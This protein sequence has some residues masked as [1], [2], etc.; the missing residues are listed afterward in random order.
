MIKE[1]NMK[2]PLVSIITVCLNSEKYIEQAI[3]S[4]ICQTYDN[5]EYIVIDGCSTDGTL[6]IIK[7]YED[8]ITYWISERDEGIS[9]AFNKGIKAAKGDLIGILNSDDWYEKNTVEKVAKAYDADNDIGVVH[10]DVCFHKGSKPLFIISPHPDPERLWREMIYNH[11]SCFI[12]RKCYENF[13]MFEK[14]LTVAMDYELLLRF[15]VNNA[16]F[17]Y[18]PGVLTNQRCEGKSEKQIIRSLIEVYRSVIK[19]GY[20]RYKALFWLMVSV[21]R[22][23]IRSILGVDNKFL[24]IIR[25]LSKRK[26]LV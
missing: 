26:R 25:K 5:V 7:K 4:V 23:S 24:Q 17:L 19:Y 16:K 3:R 9:D 13:G 18:I 8:K 12:N 22:K 15:Y 10:G 11:P 6:D 20:P 2:S 1:T 21:F 14:S